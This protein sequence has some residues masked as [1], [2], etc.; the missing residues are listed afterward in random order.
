MFWTHAAIGVAV[1]IALLIIP[2]TVVY[3]KMMLSRTTIKVMIILSVG[4]TLY[5]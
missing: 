4:K 5:L 2:I 3:K 1:D